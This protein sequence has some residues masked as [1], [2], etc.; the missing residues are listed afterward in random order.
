MG[1][2]NR[3]GDGLRLGMTHDLHITL[4]AEEVSKV[5]IDHVIKTIDLG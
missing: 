2:W 4:T 1:Y 3:A 5:L